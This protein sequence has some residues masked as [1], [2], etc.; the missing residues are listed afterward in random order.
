MSSTAPD[1]WELAASERSIRL[2]SS[3]TKGN[4]SKTEGLGKAAE[5]G[6]AGLPV[7]MLFVP[8]AGKGV[9]PLDNCA[10]VGKDMTQ[11]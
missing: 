11:R 4:T 3:C 8:A 5:L 9:E 1:S 7:N 2:T 10:G 6:V